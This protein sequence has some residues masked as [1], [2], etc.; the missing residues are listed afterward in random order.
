[1]Q[2]KQIMNFKQKKTKCTDVF[3]MFKG[4]KNMI[5]QEEYIQQKKERINTF[6]SK[7]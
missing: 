1:M 5:K 2:G 7:Q 4:K 3:T 6:T